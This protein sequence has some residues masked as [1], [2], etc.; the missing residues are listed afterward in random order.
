MFP[1]FD[2]Y[3]T[4]LLLLS[5]QGLVFSLL[6]F[7]RY[8]RKGNTADFL[9]GL[10]LL[11]TCYHQTSYTIGFMGWYDT[12]RNTKVNYYLINL[13][14][15]LAPLIYFYIKSTTTPH[16]MLRRIK[17]WHFLPVGIYALIKVVI[18]IYDSM[19]PGYHEVQ[20]GYLV[21][22]FEWKYLNPILFLVET[23]QMLLYLAFS[24]QLLY[25][26]RSRVRQ[27]FANSYQLELNWLQNF[28]IAYSF[29]YL[30]NVFQTVIDAMITDLHWTQEWWYY[31]LSGI[32]II[33]VGIKGYFTQITALQRVDFAS[34]E[35]PS[36]KSVP[37]TSKQTSESPILEKKALLSDFF[38]KER[39]YLNPE[40]TLG[41]LAGQLNM[42]REELSHIINNGFDSRFNDF[43]NA[44]R[45]R[46]V[47]R[48]IADGKLEAFSML[49]LAHEAGFNSKATFNRAFKKVTNQSPTEYLKSLS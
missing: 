13:S 37:E 42:S 5:V 8:R 48:L 14:L 43:I 33:Y 4:T 36:G 19:L 20:N 46:E 24:F 31:F 15:L 49:G 45:I 6:L 30:F 28:L 17:F 23:L 21:V 10:V 40:V 25:E 26:F 18:L 41:S 3:S 38:E 32:A 39:P 27:Y 9:L 7:D 29:L 22:H 44:Y 12:F 1:T 2:I 35:V 34:F 11:I 47:K 16:F